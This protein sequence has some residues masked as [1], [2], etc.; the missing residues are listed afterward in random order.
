MALQLDISSV[1]V[2]AVVV[3]VAVV[4]VD[5]VVV[6]VAAGVGAGVGQSPS[7]RR[8]SFGDVTSPVRQMP[9]VL[10]Q[11]QLPEQNIAQVSTAHWSS[12]SLRSVGDAVGAGVGDTVGECNA[13]PAQVHAHRLVQK[14][15]AQPSLNSI[16]SQRSSACLLWMA[17]HP[18]NGSAG[19]VPEHPILK[20]APSSTHSPSSV[21]KHMAPAPFGMWYTQ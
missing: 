5:V 8:C 4:P 13:H 11:P 19:K 21:A 2:V 9:V 12:S 1:C 16:S 15:L 7:L 20:C 17:S 6:R 10:S 18:A 3:D 14:L